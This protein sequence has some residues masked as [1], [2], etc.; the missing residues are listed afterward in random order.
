M[1]TFSTISI[2]IACM[3]FSVA[4]MHAAESLVTAGGSDPAKSKET[5]D[6]ASWQNISDEFFKKLDVYDVTP[7]YIR[8]CVGMAVTP[9]GEI[10][11]R[12]RRLA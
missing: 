6:T 10:E 11:P 9:A 8:R 4:S 5:I 2:G 1:K 3:L 12:R 7:A